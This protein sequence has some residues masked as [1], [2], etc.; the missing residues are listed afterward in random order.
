[1]EL[2]KFKEAYKIREKINELEGKVKDTRL[3]KK[4][5][6][7]KIIM[8]VITERGDKIE[9]IFKNGDGIA[10]LIIEGLKKEIDRCERNFQEI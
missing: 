9:V 3:L 5:K 2:E 4:S 10:E 1:M 6:D 8:N 7:N